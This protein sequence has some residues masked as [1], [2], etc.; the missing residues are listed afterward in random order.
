MKA[1][2]N[3]GRPP[4]VRKAVLLSALN[5]FQKQ[6]EADARGE[7]P[8]YRPRGYKRM[9]RYSEKKMKKKSWFSKGNY[10]S[11]IMIPVTPHSKL[12]KKIEHRLKAIKTKEKV[13]V[14]EKPGKKFIEVLRNQTNKQKKV[15][16]EDPNC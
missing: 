16:C 1:M 12:K 7:T 6:K 8:L 11:Y 3:S 5:G 15:I 2:Q 14:V 4:N 9:E 13:K 10:T